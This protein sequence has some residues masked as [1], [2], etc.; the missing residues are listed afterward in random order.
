MPR[1]IPLIAIAICVYLVL[2]NRKPKA[3]PQ[4]RPSPQ[5]DTVPPE[6]GLLPKSRQN[7]DR[8][9]P[10]P[11]LDALLATVAAGQWEPSAELLAAT[12]KDWPRRSAI[13]Y[14]LAEAAAKDDAWLK[15]W[16]AARPDDPDAALVH[17]RSLVV[18][19]WDIRGGKL[20]K[21]T[22]QEQFEGFRQVLLRSREAIARAA[23]V[24]PDD[25][26]PHI[27]AISTGLGLGCSHEDMH[28]LWAEI[29]SRDPLNH[30]AHTTAL[31][32]WCA[33]WRGSEELATAFARDAAASAPAGSLLTVLPLIAWYEHADPEIGKRDYL[34][35]E[36]TAAVDALLADVAAAPAGHPRIRQARHL[37]AYFLLHQKRWAESA[38]QFRAVDGWIH[39]LPWRYSG[40]PAHMYT[41]LRDLA[42]TKAARAGS[43]GNSATEAKR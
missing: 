41:T 4:V 23:E 8:S 29:T 18:L 24:A 28:A 3:A 33:K 1:L 21:Y 35:P 22:T 15:A 10:D 26:T 17:A 19:A 2:K 14:E 42:I 27:T 43:P 25:P 5:A 6:P 16:Q 40:N 13:S 37:L 36:L 20:A 12:G 34:T 30:E 32:Y 7:T 39:A 11:E 38:E 31:Q 9:G